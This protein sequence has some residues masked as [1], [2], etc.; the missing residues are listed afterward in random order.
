MEDAAE[1]AG[2]CE[3]HQPLGLVVQGP[4]VRPISL[5]LAIRVARV[6]LRARFGQVEVA[7]GA[8]VVLG[9][10][11]HDVGICKRLS[12]VGSAKDFG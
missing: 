6:E 10:A 3:I 1:A 12:I 7:V 4:K 11:T 8:V 5:E 9:A 2:L